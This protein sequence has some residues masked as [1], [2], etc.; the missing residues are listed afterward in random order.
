MQPGEERAIRA[1]LRQ[2]ELRR[3]AVEQC[4]LARMGISGEAGGGGLVGAVRAI[5]AQLNSIVALVRGPGPSGCSREP[6]SLPAAGVRPT[7]LRA[8]AWCL[9][10]TD[11]QRFCPAR[12]PAPQEQRAAAELQAAGVDEGEEEEEEEE[13]EAGSSG[14]G[15]SSASRRQADESEEEGEEGAALMEDALEALAQAQELVSRAGALVGEYGLRFEFSGQEQER[16]RERLQVGRAAE[17]PI[18]RSA[19]AAAAPALRSGGALDV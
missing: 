13:G 5:Q 10:G 19:A 6:G 9:L 8:P 4:G 3:T 1:R 7:P 17:Q 2:A 11:R 12:R 15:S 18:S 14:S 16:L